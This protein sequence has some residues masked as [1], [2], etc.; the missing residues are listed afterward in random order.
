M[1]KHSEAVFSLNREYVLNFEI[2]FKYKPEMI[3]LG[4]LNEIPFIRFPPFSVFLYVFH[5]RFRSEK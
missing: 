1:M 4:A 5:R 3:P 2:R